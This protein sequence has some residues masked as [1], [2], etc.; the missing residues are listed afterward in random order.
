MTINFLFFNKYEFIIFFSLTYLSLMYFNHVSTDSNE[1]IFDENGGRG[2][3]ASTFF[4]RLAS[5]SK[6]A[7]QDSD[8]VR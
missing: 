7:S 3:P 2:T 5:Y 4:K 8:P 1:Y 6:N